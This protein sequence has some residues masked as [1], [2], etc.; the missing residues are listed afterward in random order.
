LPKFGD[1]KLP[2]TG[3]EAKKE[4]PVKIT[5]VNGIGVYALWFFSK[6]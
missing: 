2:I 5:E 6:L 4:K 1:S 3:V